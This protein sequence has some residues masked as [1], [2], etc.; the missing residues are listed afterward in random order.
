VCDAVL[1]SGW[2][3]STLQ[4]QWDIS[5]VT[6][7]L[8]NIHLSTYFTTLLHTI[9][10]TFLWRSAK[11]RWTFGFDGL[12]DLHKYNIYLITIIA[13]FD[14]ELKISGTAL[15]ADG[16]YLYLQTCC[17]LARRELRE[18]MTTFYNLLSIIIRRFVLNHFRSNVL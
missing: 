8:H 17:E 6:T 2:S 3:A 16:S 13:G 7:H 5:L 12:R 9:H 15:C 10:E 11:R 14:D 18:R 4:A 1:W